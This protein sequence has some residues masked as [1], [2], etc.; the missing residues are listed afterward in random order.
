MKFKM[1]E[2]HNIKFSGHVVSRAVERGISEIAL[3]KIRNFKV[4]EWNLNIQV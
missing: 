2:P 4:D 3:N 1:S